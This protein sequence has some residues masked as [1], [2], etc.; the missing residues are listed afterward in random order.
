[1]KQTIISTIILLCVLLFA[2]TALAVTVQSPIKSNAPV[3]TQNHKAVFVEL[4]NQD[5]NPAY[6]GDTVELRFRLE[7]T[8]GVAAD[9]VT[10]EL[11]DDYPFTVIDGSN[12]QV[13]GPLYPYQTDKNYIY[14]KYTMLVNKDAPSGERLLRLRY[15]YEDDIW[16]VKTL[17]VDVFNKDFAQIIYVDKAMIEPGKETDMK[18]TINNLGNGPL[19]NLVFSWTQPSGVI[20]PVYGDDAKYVKY[21]DV[22]KSIDLTYTVIADTK[23]T[24]GLYPLELTLQ[25]ESMT[26]STMSTIET[27]A[28]VLVG[29]GTDFDV[30]F[31]E[32]TAGQTSLSVANTGNNPA[33]SVSVRIPEQQG[34]TI[35]GSSSA[36]IGNLDKGDYTIVSFAI[37]Q[38]NMTMNNSATQRPADAG[39]ITQR[40]FTRTG[41][42]SAGRSA[43]ML[44]VEIDYTDTTGQRHTVQ[45]SINVQTRGGSGF[46][47]GAARTTSSSFFTSNLFYAI[48]VIA[49][50]GAGV[51]IYLH[52]KRQDKAKSADKSR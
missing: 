7:N 42:F 22:G 40:N 20:L 41:N 27:T 35:T 3:S 37:S 9:K 2:T 28:G 34:Y 1:M 23:A 44:T 10:I 21:L 30:S 50:V 52:R 26:N 24:A 5:P 15:S 6:A 39:T 14:F 51:Y 46:A 31:S 36:I 47:N 29:G 43:N 13:I 48:V 19:K 25:Y 11:I 38:R 32:S 17:S 33:Q 18:F 8:G 4:L 16:V 12:T 45:K 49:V